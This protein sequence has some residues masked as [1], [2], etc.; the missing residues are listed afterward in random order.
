MRQEI[1]NVLTNICMHNCC[2]SKVIE[3]LL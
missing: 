2:V 1:N 3:P